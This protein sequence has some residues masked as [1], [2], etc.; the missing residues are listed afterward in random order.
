MA[1][2]YDMVTF[3]SVVTSIKCLESLIAVVLMVQITL[4]ISNI[5]TI[6][7]TIP[8]EIQ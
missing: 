5:N 3:Q 6:P 1:T 7:F 8:P 4:N 2:G